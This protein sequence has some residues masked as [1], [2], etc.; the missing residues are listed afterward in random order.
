LSIRRFREAATEFDRPEPNPNAG[1][2]QAMEYQMRGKFNG[3]FQIIVQ[4]E[5]P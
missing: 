4:G 2:R 5:Q 1:G 3:R